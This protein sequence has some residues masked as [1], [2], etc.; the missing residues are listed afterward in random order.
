MSEWFEIHRSVG[1]A[2]KYKNPTHG[3]QTK[4]NKSTM[5][6]IF[7]K[8]YCSASTFVGKDLDEEAS[9]VIIP[10]KPTR[11][12]KRSNLHSF[13][14]HHKLYFVDIDCNEDNSAIVITSTQD[15]NKKKKDN[16]FRLPGIIDNPWWKE[17]EPNDDQNETDFS[18]QFINNTTDFQMSKCTN[19]ASKFQGL[20][21]SFPTPD[22]TLD[23]KL[24]SDENEA[25]NLFSFQ[26]IE[27]VLKQ[28]N[29]AQ[30]SVEDEPIFCNKSNGDCNTSSD[31]SMDEC[32]CDRN[33]CHEIED[34]DSNSIV[35]SSSS[36]IYELFDDLS[37]LTNEDSLGDIDIND[38]A[39][40][41]VEEENS[42][43]SDQLTFEDMSI[44][45]EDIWKGEG[46]ENNTHAMSCSLSEEELFLANVTDEEKTS[47]DDSILK[48]QKNNYNKVKDQTHP[49]FSNGLHYEKGFSPKDELRLA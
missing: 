7:Q 36:A 29:E 49:D 20:F 38:D 2:Y 44:L 23:S 43:L 19:I 17:Q 25:L 32:H 21:K 12:R 35:S 31:R 8:K 27:S 42:L 40:E 22:K 24:E 1:E 28:M 16:M 39:D 15:K 11:N 34:N 46:R 13:H 48:K 5:I 10:E 30:V 9:T 41:I 33:S 47:L 4:C 3:A 45:A 37:I 18:T 14:F 26:N 6:D